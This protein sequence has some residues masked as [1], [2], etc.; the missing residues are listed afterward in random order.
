MQRRAKPLFLKKILY[1]LF[2]M[3]GLVLLSVIAGLALLPGGQSFAP[4]LSGGRFSIAE[5]SGWASTSPFA[6][7]AVAATRDRRM[8]RLRMSSPP[9]DDLSKQFE[10]VSPLSAP[11]RVQC[12]APPS[13]CR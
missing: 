5:P 3:A 1:L 9:P 6:R 4:T 7:N 13:H 8:L 11:C 10:R 12:L 2:S